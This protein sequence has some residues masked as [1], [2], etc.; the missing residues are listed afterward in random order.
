MGKPWEVS[1]KTKKPWEIAVQKVPEAESSRRP[2]SPGDTRSIPF[3]MP[4]GANEPRLAT[5]GTHLPR[6]MEDVGRSLA[7]GVPFAD[8]F[9]AKMNEVTGI[10]G[11]YEE[12]LQAERARNAEI[13]PALAIP[14]E[15]V[16][17]V[18]STI[19]APFLAPAKLAPLK[20]IPNWV[21]SV[22]LGTGYGAAYGASE[23]EQGERLKGAGGGALL[24]GGTGAAAHGV[25][26]GGRGMYRGGMNL[27]DDYYRPTPRAA[28]IVGQHLRADKVP[29]GRA[30]A[31]LGELGKE[32]MLLDTGDFVTRGLARGV[33]GQPGEAR[34][35]ILGRLSKRSAGDTDRVLKQVT[36]RLGPGDYFG[37][38]QR[39]LQ[40]LRQGAAESYGPAY[41]AHPNIGTPGLSELAQRPPVRQGIREALEIARNDKTAGGTN[42]INPKVD[43]EIDEFLKGNRPGQ[44]LSLEAWD[45]VKQGLDAVMEMPAYRNNKTGWLNKKG[46]G[47][48]G[49]KRS[50]TGELD[51][52]TGGE[53]SLYKAARKQYGDDA[54]VLQALRDGMNFNNLKHEQITARMG[55]L[56]GAGQEAYR[57]GAVRKIV[58]IAENV[59]DNASVARRLF[60]KKATRKKLRALFP[61]EKSWQSFKS[62]ME[63]EVTFFN[64]ATEIGAGSRTAEMLPEIEN[65]RKMAAVVGVLLGSNSPFGHPL[66]MAGMARRAAHGA[67]GGPPEEMNKAIARIL[68]TRNPAEQKR[69]FD[70]MAPYAKEQALKHPAIRAAIIGT[71]QQQPYQAQ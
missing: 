36:R 71:Q 24:G 34:G 51:R 15:V 68:T 49:L 1:K 19:A 42:W 64:T 52:A 8:E 39:F 43:V 56:S 66:L 59:S 31:D 20:N 54:E 7:R 61:D 10:G 40:K 62:R 26:A 27:I 57:N 38:E 2:Y 69:Y 18:A 14:A 55:E 16:G 22:G 70:M 47:I 30:M 37:D 28:Q 9:A 53:K 25:M 50:L 46:R 11:S 35:T 67:V 6:A 65:A 29:L 4:Y 63:A 48:A 33:A 12:N 23:A 41:K 60:N 3:D 32:G 58:D 44:G 17:G 21:K 5:A 13:N 45:Y